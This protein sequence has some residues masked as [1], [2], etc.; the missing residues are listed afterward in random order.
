MGKAKQK[1]VERFW[2]KMNSVETM[3]IERFICN[4]KLKD[5]YEAYNV[6]DHDEYQRFI[7]LVLKNTEIVCFK[8]DSWLDDLDE[9]RHSKWGMLSENVVEMTNEEGVSNSSGSYSRIYMKNDY[10]LYEFFMGLKNIFDFEEDESM[11]IKLEDPLFIKNGEI[12]CHTLTHEGYCDVA[13]DIYE[14]LQKG[15]LH[16]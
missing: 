12:I 7:K 10:T 6:L 16:S 1:A 11:G 3:R 4:A 5:S 8:V 15:F 13:E 9:L 2:K 14:L